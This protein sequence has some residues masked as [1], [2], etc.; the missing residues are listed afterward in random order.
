MDRIGMIG[1][2]RM[3]LAMIR[4][5]IKAGFGVTAT[6]INADQ[7]AKA[8]AEGAKAAASV[9]AVGA[10]SDFVIVAVGFD[11]GH[12][13]FAIGLTQIERAC[14]TVGLVPAGLVLEAAGHLFGPTRLSRIALG[15]GQ[16]SA[17]TRR[18]G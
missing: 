5:L 12:A 11:L 2:G 6:D 1:P 17:E 13:P 16:R 9:A 4:H 10:A 18:V 15:F 3:G 14:S 7:L 8:E